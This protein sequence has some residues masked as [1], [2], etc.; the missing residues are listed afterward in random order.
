MKSQEALSRNLPHVTREGSLSSEL[1]GIRLRRRVKRKGEGT[2][3]RDYSVEQGEEF[4][5][6]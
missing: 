1:R 6:S 2:N 3:W 4:L 5:L